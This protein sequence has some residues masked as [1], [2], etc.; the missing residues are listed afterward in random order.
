MDHLRVAGTELETAHVTQRGHGQ[1]DDE[2]PRDVGTLGRQDEWL[3]QRDDE[4]GRAELPPFGPARHGQS[5]RIA[6]RRTVCSPSADGVD[7]LLAERMLSDE[8]RATRCGFPGRHE[9]R[10]S[11]CGD[12]RGARLDVVERQQAERCGA[13]GVMAHRATIEQERCDVLRE[14]DRSYRTALRG[15]L[16]RYN[17]R[18]AERDEER[19]TAGH[20]A[21]DGFVAPRI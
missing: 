11:R 14:R 12:Q 15:G 13:I 6:L 16:R 9:T 2:D 8:L 19:R 5:L 20:W 4:I 17:C 18:N 10:L 21:H 7:L 3:R 1:R